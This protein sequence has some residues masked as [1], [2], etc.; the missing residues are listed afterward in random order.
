MNFITICI[1]DDWLIAKLLLKRLGIKVG[2]MATFSWVY[3]CF[4]CFNNGKRSTRMVIENIIAEAR[5]GV[6]WHITNF[7]FDTCFTWIHYP[8]FFE[9]I[10]TSF[11]QISINVNLPGFEF[12]KEFWRL[13]FIFG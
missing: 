8:F 13:D 10:P 11:S 6:I 4:L 5:F 9:N 3:C 12:G 7:Y 1:V 2:L